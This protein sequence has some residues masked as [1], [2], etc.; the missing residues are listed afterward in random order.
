MKENINKPIYTLTGI[1]IH[2]R[3]IGKHVG[4]PTANIEIAK[5]TF[6][7]KTGVYVAD[8][9]LSGKIY[10]GVTHIGTRPTLDNDSF[11]SIETHIFDFDKD[12]YGCT[13]TVNLYKKLREVRKFNELSLLL[14]QITNDRIMAQEF[15]GLKQTNHTLHIDINRHCVILE[16]QEVYLSTNEFEVLYLLLQSP[17]TTF[18]KEQIYEQIWHEPTNNHL[19]A[20]EN[21]IFQIRKGFNATEISNYK[22]EKIGLN[23]I[24]VKVSEKDDSLRTATVYARNTGLFED[25]YHVYFYSDEIKKLAEPL[26]KDKNYIQKYDI[27]IEGRPT[28]TEWTGKES[29]EEYI[30]KAEYTVVLKIHL[31]DGKAESEYAEEISDLMQEIMQCDLNIHILVYVNGENPIFYSLPEEDR[32]SDV[33]FILK[34]MYNIKSLQESIEHAD[35]WKKQN[36]N[37]AKDYE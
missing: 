26:C 30:E 22:E 8:I 27:E 23:W 19:H 2:G 5:N 34:E 3:G 28:S 21:T 35:E 32:Q 31:Q 25:S 33:D 15:W 1:V 7:P 24:L 11:V 18:T 13:I 12:I 36:Q 10:Y 16:Q 14:E 6:L 29:I 4:T 37:N 17:Q 9:L 20:V